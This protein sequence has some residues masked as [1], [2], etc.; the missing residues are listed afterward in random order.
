M[1][2]FLHPSPDPAFAVIVAEAR[3]RRPY[4]AANTPSRASVP[5]GARAGF[6]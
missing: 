4:R 6:I 2:H 5:A 1:S 3:A